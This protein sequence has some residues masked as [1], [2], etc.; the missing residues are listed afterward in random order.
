M[1]L[2]CLFRVNTATLTASGSLPICE[3]DD[4]RAR[5]N[6]IRFDHNLRIPV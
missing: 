1:V 3:P 2:F 4:A 5:H 6:H